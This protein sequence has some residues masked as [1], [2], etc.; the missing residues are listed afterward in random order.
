[1]LYHLNVVFTT[2]F[3]NLNFNWS[4]TCIYQSTVLY[5]SP[6][7]YIISGKQ[8]PIDSHKWNI[9]ERIRKNQVTCIHGETG[10]GKSTRV[11][12]FILEE[13]HQKM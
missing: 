4:Q 7:V 3:V 9:L 2:Y 11:P 13:Y 8:L 10:C 6:F 5:H 1:M 12:E